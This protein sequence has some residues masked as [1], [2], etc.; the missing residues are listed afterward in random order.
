M[1]YSSWVGTLIAVHLLT[2]SATWLEA[3]PFENWAQRLPEMRFLEDV[4]FGNDTF[5]AVGSSGQMLS[6][7]NGADW[8]LH[9]ANYEY[10]F[11]G[12]T[13]GGGQFVAVGTFTI[14]LDPLICIGVS[15]DGQS[16]VVLQNYTPWVFLQSVARGNDTTVAVSRG[17]GFYYSTDF[18]TWTPVS[19]GRF[20]SVVFGKDKFVA[21]GRD[22]IIQTSPNGRDWAVANS[23]VTNRLT[24]VAYG[25]GTYMA[26]GG[27]GRILR[28]GD[29]STW[30]PC[31]S[32]TTNG[33]SSIA[34]GG[35]V[36]MAAGYPVGEVVS[37]T[38]GE[39]WQLHRTDIPDPPDGRIRSLKALA[40][41]A[42]SF[43]ALNSDYAPGCCLWSTSIFQSASVQV[44][45]GGSYRADLNGFEVTAR[46]GLERAYTLQESTNLAD[47]TDVLV[48]TN[49]GSTNIFV[50][51]SA[52]RTPHRF[53]RAVAP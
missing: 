5:V 27:E 40:F 17:G 41:G 25:N 47:W 37:S 1:K 52:S 6:S 2:T 49:S 18:Q 22:G 26:V 35:G 21:V 48:F 13:Y 9:Q 10:G 20:Y 16:W 46:G 30:I 42:G 8:A 28:S 33:L 4:T 19:T 11:Y 43:V 34:F 44:E 3:D 45:L 50:D 39:L 32:P 12:V 31:A 53:F 7:K 29:A 23:G 36:F 24:D 51:T 15:T 14:H 38:D